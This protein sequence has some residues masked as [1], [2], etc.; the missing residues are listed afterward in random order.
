MK[1]LDLSKNVW[2][3]ILWWLTRILFWIP[4]G[5]PFVFVWF[6]CIYKREQPNRPKKRYFIN[7]NHQKLMFVV[8]IIKLIMLIIFTGIDAIWGLY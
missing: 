1:D 4:Y 8:G 5:I 2:T 6:L 3:K 7:Y